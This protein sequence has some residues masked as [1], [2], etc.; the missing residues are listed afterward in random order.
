MTRVGP[1]AGFQQYRMKHSE[2][3]YFPGYPVNFHPITQANPISSHQNEPT[4]KAYDE[5]FQRHRKT[6]AG[7]S[8][9]SPQLARR[10]EN[11]QQDQTQGND[12]QPG[13]YYRVESVGL[14]AV[15]SDF[16]EKAFQPAIEENPDQ[17]DSYDDSR[18]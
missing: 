17:Q 15:Q 6:C 13:A 16:V 4:H 8:Q 10:T 11:H 5:V 1:V 9:E 7:K 2:L 18:T 14:T 12:L 3:D